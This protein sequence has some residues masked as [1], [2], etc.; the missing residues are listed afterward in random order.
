VIAGLSWFLLAHLAAFLG[1]HE[2][3]R[4]AGTGRA[5]LDAVIF[6]LVRI[7]LISASV[8]AAGLT[9]LLTPAGLGLFSAAALAGLVALGA[10]RHVR[11]PALPDAGRVLWIAAAVVGLRLLLQAWFFS[12][13]LGDALAYHLPKIAEWVRAGR[14][15]REM[16]LH[17]HATF[18]AGFELVETWWVVFLRHDVLIE[19]AGAEFLVLAF[20][21]T[22]ALAKSFPLTDRSAFLAALLY[23]LTPGL[24]LSALSCLNDTPV[25]ALVVATFAL[26]AGRVPGTLVLMTVGLGIGVKATYAYALP[27]LVVIGFLARKDRELPSPSRVWGAGLA[28]LGGVTGGFWY[29]RNLLWYGNPVYPVG[30]PGYSES[31]VAVQSGPSLRS[32][33]ANASDLLD[34]RIYDNQGPYGANVDHIAGWGPAVFACGLLAMLAVLGRDPPFRR[35][36]L[37]FTVSL[38]SC[39]LLMIHDPWSMKY[40]FFFPA[41]LCVA[42]ARVA[43]ENRPSLGLAAVA[44]LFAF[45]GTLL[46][47]DL[48]LRHLKVLAAQPWPT[49][50]ALSLAEP[51]LPDS[52]VGCFGGFRAKAYL[53]YGP[54]FSRK[55]V[56][57]RPT[58]SSDLIETLQRSGVEHLYAAPV[59]IRDETLLGEC[60][61]RG[62]LKRVGGSFYRLE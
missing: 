38:G 53:L 23:I 4:R 48:P 17:P 3:T 52:R 28:L 10:H 46:P 24:H 7:I 9:G 26:V 50:T 6:L 47:Y 51:S 25:A 35:L 37:S 59:T 61:Q 45:I 58:S 42:V 14:F 29:G 33:W 60:V 20:A 43:E 16:G 39:F 41:I 54:D 57:L 32:F 55:V 12:P 31:A 62:R 18:P 22:Y 2:I 34:V 21:A 19:M 11:R 27:G 8:L 5:A 15:T 1:A 56:Y 13:H 36:S 49:R 30:T 40:V 44:G